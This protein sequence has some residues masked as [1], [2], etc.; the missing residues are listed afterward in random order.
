[1]WLSCGIYLDFDDRG[2]EALEQLLARDNMPKP[3]YLVNT[4]PDRGQVSWK[5][6]GFGA[7]QAEETM[8]AI[9]WELRTRRNRH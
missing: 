5:L 9:V 4:S 3:N 8:R 7:D 2:T 1:M 6:Q